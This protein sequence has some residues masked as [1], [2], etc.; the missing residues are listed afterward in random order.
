MGRRLTAEEC[1]KRFERKWPGWELIE[2]SSASGHCRVRHKCGNLK[3]YEIYSNV[4]KRG[5]TCQECVSTKKWYWNVGD[6]VGDLTIINRRALPNMLQEYQYKCNACGFDCSKP[7]YIQGVYQSEYWTTGH[8]IKRSQNSGNR[9]CACCCGKVVQPGINDVATTVSE[10]VKYFYDKIEANKWTKASEHKVRVV[11]PICNNTQPNEIAIH[12]LVDERFD[13]F[14]CGNN[15][16]YPEK[17]MYFLLKEIGID[18][19]MHKTFDWSKEVYDEYDGKLHKREYDFYIP[20]INLIVE[21][22]GSQHYRLTF[23]WDKANDTLD[24]LEHRQKIDKDK[25]NLAEENGYNYIA[26]DCNNSYMNYIKN[27]ILHSKLPDLLDLSSIDWDRIGKK[28]LSGIAKIVIADKEQNPTKISIELA[29]Q[30]NVSLDSIIR[31]LKKAGIYDVKAERRNA[32]I[33]RSTPVYSPELNKAFRSIK[34]VSEELGIHSRTISAAS[35]PNNSCQIH[36][37]KHPVTG[38]Y[39]SWERWSIEQYER[40]CKNNSQVDY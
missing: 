12:N 16:S 26:I 15:I 14:H 29:R 8:V 21:I 18:F 37:G 32:G 31:W 27:N 39:L 22:H 17:F 9:G 28:A 1:K 34:L 40:W 6:Q 13:C 2:F 5:P 19:E 20:S 36:A 10:V 24:V 35:D 11:C 3:N 30:Y 23:S 7:V 33:K 25:Q 38:E 4:E